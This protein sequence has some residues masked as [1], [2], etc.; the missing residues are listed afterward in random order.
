MWASLKYILFFII[1]LFFLSLFLWFVVY[2]LWG[3][4][5]IYSAQNK[6]SKYPGSGEAVAQVEAQLLVEPEVGPLF[7]APLGDFEIYNG[8]STHKVTV[9][10]AQEKF[11]YAVGRFAGWE[12]IPGSSEE[13]LLL[14]YPRRIETG[15]FRVTFH[16]SDLF[17]MDS[18]NLW[19]ED[20]G[21]KWSV[22]TK[23]NFKALKMSQLKSILWQG[24]TVIILPVYDQQDLVKKDA[25][26]YYLARAVIVRR[27]GIKI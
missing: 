10:E 9:M 15:R 6:V 20:V 4:R 23:N 11:I 26:G 21:L 5:L 7:Y 22:T 18:T 8:L 3:R 13:Y 14:K 17:E 16:Q 27:V 2:P 24:D 1:L 19:V 12:K 25:N